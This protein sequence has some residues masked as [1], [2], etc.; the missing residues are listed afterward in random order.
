MKGFSSSIS[1]SSSYYSQY[2]DQFDSVVMRSQL[3]S[4]GG[5]LSSALPFSDFDK[6]SQK[7]ILIVKEDLTKQ[8]DASERGGFIC[9]SEKEKLDILRAQTEMMHTD[10]KQDESPWKTLKAVKSDKDARNI[11]MRQG[12]FESAGIN[13][14]N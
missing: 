8:I 5:F 12:A 13:A 7:H 9:F 2:D 10:Y 11:I 6:Q 1:S 14:T 4:G 3:T